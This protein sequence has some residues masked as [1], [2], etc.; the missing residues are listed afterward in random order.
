MIRHLRYH[1]TLVVMTS[2]AVA[3]AAAGGLDDLVAGP[4]T[5]VAGDCQFTEGPAWHPDG[6]LLF[7][8]IPNERIL[9]LGADGELTV[10]LKPSGGSNGLMC[11]AAGNVYACQGES[12]QVA[13]LR[14]NDD[15]L[16]MLVRV[17]AENFEDKPLNKP[18]DLAVDASG[19]L[20]FTDPN[21]RQEEPTQPVQGV[22]Y[23][24]AGG[25]VTRVIDDLPRPNGIL[26][27]P[28]GKSLYVA[29][30]EFAQ[31]VRYPIQG[32]GQLGDGDVLYAGDKELDGERGPD[33][34]ALDSDGRI[35]ASY[36]EVTVINPDGTLIGRIEVPERPANCAFGGADNHTLY[37]TAR[38]SLYQVPLTVT[39]MALQS[40]GAN[41]TKEYE[42]RE[43]KLAVPSSWKLQEPDNRLRLLQFEV[44]AHGD[45]EE[46]AEFVVFPP[47]GGSEKDNIDRWI[48]QWDAEGRTLKMTKGMVPQGN[49]IL[50]ELAGTYNKPIGPPIQRRTM[51]APGY[52]M[53]GVIL[54]IEG[55]GNYFLKMTGPDAT[56]SA[57]A[58]AFRRAFGADAANE[59]PHSLD[60]E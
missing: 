56:V 49:Y 3:T 50:V 44:P 10:W 32:P 35:Y 28:D 33:G 41:A 58:A 45:D 53:Y 30:I 55:G 21:Y 23:V 22:Y 6:Y 39:G 34:M 8:D 9:R 18:N 25:A 1:L 4:L 26:V 42:A 54:S 36:R 2:G 24:A 13:L 43:L 14:S 59:K 11:D 5:K 47:F 38:T 31:I 60:S 57:N 37:I 16:G 40:P 29:N 52:R 20:Y 46:P 17:L 27:S 7:S 19:G 15:G 51:Q 12:R 48:A